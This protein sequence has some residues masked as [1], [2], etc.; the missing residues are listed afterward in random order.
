MALNPR[1]DGSAAPEL[2]ERVYPRKSPVMGPGAQG[3]EVASHPSLRCPGQTLTHI[4]LLFTEELGPKTL[5]SKWGVSALLVKGDLA[6]SSKSSKFP[7]AAAANGA[8]RE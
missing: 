1:L 5:L 3:I 2:L 8:E 6:G 7:V 4:T